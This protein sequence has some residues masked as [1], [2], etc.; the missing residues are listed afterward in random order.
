MEVI[1]N[2]MIHDDDFNS[3]YGKSLS[4]VDKILKS[5]PSI[6]I[7][8]DLHRDGMGGNKKLRTAIKVDGKNAARVMFVVGTNQ[9]LAH[10]AWK[11]NFKLALKIQ[12]K[13]NETMVQ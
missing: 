6:R 7:V 10:S 3:A 4:T 5:Y 8:I 12:E 2:G 1:H 11:E 9:T 13:L